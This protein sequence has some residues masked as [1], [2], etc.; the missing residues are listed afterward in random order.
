MIDMT[1]KELIKQVFGPVIDMMNDRADVLANNP[2][3]VLAG[4]DVPP[5]LRKDPAARIGSPRDRQ[6][7][8]ERQTGYRQGPPEKQTGYRQGP[9]ERQTGDRQG[10][11]ERQM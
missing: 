5:E 6:G 11:G 9:G 3:T 7:P 8:G 4:N 1:V 2:E 10:P